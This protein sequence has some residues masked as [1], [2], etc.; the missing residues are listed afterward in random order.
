MDLVKENNL[1]LMSENKVLSQYIKN[2]MHASSGFFSK[3]I[4]VL[5][6]LW[7]WKKMKIE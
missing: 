2:I 3:V 1:V 4:Q 7:K 6:T 5:K